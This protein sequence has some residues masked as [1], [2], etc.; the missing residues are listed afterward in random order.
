VGKAYW[1]FLTTQEMQAL[2]LDEGT[3]WIIQEGDEA[4]APSA[5]ITYSLQAVINGRAELSVLLLLEYKG[6]K[7]EVVLEYRGD[8]CCVYA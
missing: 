5:V 2:P 6:T 8:K 1:K 4:I 3:G 7:T